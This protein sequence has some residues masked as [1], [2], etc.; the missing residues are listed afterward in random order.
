MLVHYEEEGAPMTG[1]R[2][3]QTLR[4]VSR[5]RVLRVVG[6]TGLAALVA[7]ACGGSKSTGT[8]GTSTSGGTATS[9]GSASGSAASPAAS[10][11]TPKKG[12]EFAVAVEPSTQT[13]DPHTS[14]NSQVR[15]WPHFSNLLIVHDYKSIEPLKGELVESWEQTDPTTLILKA[16]QGVKWHIGTNQAR[17][18]NA[19]DIKFNLERI[20]GKYDP[21]RIAQFGRASTVQNMDRVEVVD[22]RTAR[23]F[24]KAPNAAFLTGVSDFRNWT[25]MAETVEK[26][27]DFRDLRNAGGTGAFMVESFDAGPLCRYVANPAY[28]KEGKPYLASVKQVS[29]PDPATQQSLFFSNNVTVLDSSTPS[30]RTTIQRARP[31]A[32]ILTWDGNLWDYFRINQDRPPFTD[33]RVRQ[34]LYKALNYRDMLEST[35]GKDWWTYSSVLFSG[36]PGAM[37]SDQVAKI[38]PYNPV[39]KDQ[40]IAEAKKLMEAAG[41]L[42]GGITFKFMPQDNTSA[43]Y[44][45]T[46]VAQDQFKKIWPAMNVSLDIP[47]ELGDFTRRLTSGQ[48]DVSSYTAGP[49]PALILEMANHFRSTGGRNYTKVNNPEVER[50]IDAGVVE[51]DPNARNRILQQIEQ[52][53]VQNVW[54]I[55]IGK[56]NGSVAISNKVRGY[57]GS[58][59]GGLPGVLDPNLWIDQISI[60]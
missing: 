9:G 20:A 3:E 2:R 55:P 34:A 5:R 1:S 15:Y 23:V 14:V 21:Q 28:W 36:F 7:A 42:D 31:D 30:V 12:G 27:P 29:G 52:L 37:T 38:S 22:D 53:V 43:Y 54:V 6:G 39:T 48:F 13:L 10:G 50:L 19:S 59:S 45:H 17:D 58:G 41:Y 49:A 18:F 25:T 4:G 51:F 16:R 26:D 32:K 40:D 44:K 56:G 46:V 24:F 60:E 57:T 47:A 8:S 35:Y 33:V 11:G